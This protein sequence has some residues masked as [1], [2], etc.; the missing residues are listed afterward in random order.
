MAVDFTQRNV[1]GSNAD[2]TEELSLLRLGAGMLRQRR[3][4][5][6]RRSRTPS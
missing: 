2:K 3:S 5:K 6:P 4:M 1:T